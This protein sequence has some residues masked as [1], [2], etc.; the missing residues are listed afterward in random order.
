MT[1]VPT[2]PDDANIDQEWFENYDEELKAFHIKMLKHVQAALGLGLGLG[3]LQWFSDLHA[4]SRAVLGMSNW[5][6]SLG[7][8]H[9][10]LAG[11]HLHIGL[12]IPQIAKDPRCWLGKSFGLLCSVEYGCDKVHSTG[13]EEAGTDKTKCKEHKSN[14]QQINITLTTTSDVQAGPL[15]FWS[16]V[17][18]RCLF[19]EAVDCVDLLFK[20]FP[21]VH[22]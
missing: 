3:K 17:W 8:T 10:T 11:L 16:P 1:A 21:G 15:R 22:L 14:M 4:S 9:D 6:E 13:K 19:K 5:E 7:Q 12:G 18:R 2:V 20:M